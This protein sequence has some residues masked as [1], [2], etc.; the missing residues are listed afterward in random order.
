MVDGQL[1]TKLLSSRAMARAGQAAIARS[2]LT[3]QIYEL[4]LN[5]LLNGSMRPGQRLVEAE[6]AASV[7]TSRGPV[8]EAIGLLQR[9]GLVRADPF[10]GA[11]IIDPDDR[12][13]VEIYY[14]RSVMEGY[15]AL[16]VVQRRTADQIAE[17]RAI[18]TRMRETRGPRTTA[19]LRQLDA[20]FH[21][22]LVQLAD[23]QQLWQMWNRMRSQV[24]LYLSTVEEAF[25][26]GERLA[27]MHD[28]IVEAVLSG[29]AAEAERRVR[30][31]L[32]SN[33]LEWTA[34]NRHR[35]GRGTDERRGATEDE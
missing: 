21:G 31:Q 4:L 6:I 33:A 18:T 12:E 20:Q 3:R 16:L 15:A 8:R 29:D 23:D 24:A 5:R 22:T 32:I 27:R 19:R 1:S 2:T 11:S 14:L 25:S 34:Q 17:L 13:I 9:D 26:D 35:R 30:A 7:G 10:V 28:T